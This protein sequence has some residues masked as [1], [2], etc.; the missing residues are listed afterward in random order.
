M[1]PFAYFYGDEKIEDIRAVEDD[2][3]DKVC[4]AFKYTV[5]K[6]EVILVDIYLFLYYSY[7]LWRLFQ[8]S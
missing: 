1:I 4:N 3:K 7:V 6:H 5:N 2:F 8:T